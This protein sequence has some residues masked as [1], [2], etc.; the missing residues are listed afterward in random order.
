[1]AEE[2]DEDA[3]YSEGAPCPQCKGPTKVGFGLAGG[4]YGVYTYCEKC[5]I[6]T[7]KWQEE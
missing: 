2:N 6:V 7:D 5:G 1:M 4:G 3:T